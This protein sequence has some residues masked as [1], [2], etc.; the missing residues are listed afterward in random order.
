[1]PKPGS[2]I[3]ERYLITEQIGS[4]GFGAVYLAEDTRFKGNNRVAVKQIAQTNEILIKSFHHEA[5]LLYNLNHPNLPKVT[6]CFQQDGANFI[7]M[8]YISGKDLAQSLAKGKKFTIEEVLKIADTVLDA[9]EYLHSFEIF[10]R[11][12]KPHNIK[13]NEE[14][15][16]Y[17]LD[18]G[19]AKSDFDRNTLTYSGQSVVGFTP[20]YAPLEQVLRLDANSY[21]LL[22]SI[23]SPNLD[24][25]SVLST[26]AKSDIYS[27]GATLYYLLTNFSPEKA[28]STVRAHALWTNNPDPL[29]NIQTLNPA[30]STNLAQLIHRALELDPKNRFQTAK[31]FRYALKNSS[32]TD[33]ETKPFGAFTPP[34]QVFETE[35]LRTPPQ[36]VG[37]ENNSVT[38]VLP[39][40]VNPPT[41]KKLNLKPFIFAGL[42][43]FVFLLLGVGFAA[44]MLLPR[45]EPTKEV[46]NLNVSTPTPTLPLI[47]KPKRNLTYS[48]LVQKIRDGKKFQEPFE[49]SGQEIFE[50]GYQFQMRFTPQEDG[51][52]YVFAEGADEKGQKVLNIIFPTPQRNNGSANVLGNRQY[53]TGWNEFGGKADT[54]NFW[55]IWSK[56]KQQVLEDA[57][58]D[59][60]NGDG[61]ITDKSLMLSLQTYLVANKR[62]DQQISKDADKKLSKVE[63]T[64][65][66]IAYLLQLEH[67]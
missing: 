13:I 46:N 16:I 58:N 21:L 26:D 19:T 4:G 53:E 63:F 60:F 20:F 18:F 62:E 12:I 38:T 65:D 25:F 5:N 3:D 2:I 61:S 67:R 15:K 64:D 1:M 48:L 52:F 54:E 29:P 56:E 43:V 47:S 22:Q 17:L 44:F 27:L 39:E 36:N 57:Q 11:D 35:Q 51:F 14:G 34:N 33:F 42:G 6:N 28:I 40:K 23:N 50:N 45:S 9:L 49:S 24:Y 10:H 30:V 41:N 37:Q 7:V 31:E 55:I 32:G 8:D 66:S 59:A